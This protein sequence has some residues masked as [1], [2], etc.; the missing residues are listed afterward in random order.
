MKENKQIHG[1]GLPHEP[2]YYCPKTPEFYVGFRYQQHFEGTGWKTRILQSLHNWDLSVPGE[3]LDPKRYRVRYLDAADF[4]ELGFAPKFKDETI[5][6]YVK[7]VG[8]HQISVIH[9]P[10]MYSLQIFSADISYENPDLHTVFIGGCL[11]ISELD[12]T[13][14]HR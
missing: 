13:A 3:T 9:N 6:T 8:H 4:R 10:E 7:V 11:N 1:G 12:P 5:A 14:R 2:Q